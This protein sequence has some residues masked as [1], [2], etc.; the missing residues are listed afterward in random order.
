MRHGGE[1]ENSHVHTQ[2]TLVATGGNASE[3]FFLEIM[4]SLTELTDSQEQVVHV[5]IVQYG[6]NGTSQLC[7]LYHRSRQDVETTSTAPPTTLDTPRSL[8]SY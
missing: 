6:H 4:S 2:I 7:L 3:V 8:Y 5:K 1:M